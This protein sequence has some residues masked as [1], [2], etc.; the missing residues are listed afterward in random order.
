MDATSGAGSRLSGALL[1]AAWAA[2]WRLG[3]E[4]LEQCGWCDVEDVRQ[5]YQGLQREIQLTC[6]DSL[7]LMRDP[8]PQGISQLRL[9]PAKS[10]PRFGDAAAHIALHALEFRSGHRVRVKRPRTELTTLGSVG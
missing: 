2:R 3:G 6:L 1:R 10:V 8:E 5:R 9:R 7:Y 4:R